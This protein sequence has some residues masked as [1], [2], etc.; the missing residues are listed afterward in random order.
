MDRN[1]NFDVLRIIAAFLVLYYHCYPLTGTSY[2]GVTGILGVAMFFIIS[3]YLVTQS[4]ESTKQAHMFL[5]KRFLRIVPGLAGLTIFTV[6]I[7]GPLNTILTFKDYFTNITTWT[8]FQLI[9]I[10]Y[11]SDNLPGLFLNNPYPLVVNGS[12]WTIPVEFKLYI[13]ICALGIL[14][15]LFRRKFILALSSLAVLLYTSI[16]IPNIT[17]LNLIVDIM[18]RMGIYDYVIPIVMTTPAS[19]PTYFLIGCAFYLYRNEIKYDYRL[20]MIAL[21]ATVLTYTLPFLV[22][23]FH[24]VFLICLPYIILFA[25]QLPFKP[26]QNISTKYGDYSYGLY[27]YAFPI[28]QTLANHFKGITPL[29]MLA[30][31]TPLTLIMAYLSWRFIEKNALE[32]KKTDPLIFTRKILQGALESMKSANG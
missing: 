13:F 14:G 5:W 11:R 31:T 3:G 21:V 9:T 7:I 1:N 22:P 17:P 2:Q 12:L 32:L 8:Y 16:L 18:H 30:I 6:F 15:V 27:I 19:Y 4:W 20:C 28:Q 23:Y 24:P 10:F 29:T 25:A 26:F